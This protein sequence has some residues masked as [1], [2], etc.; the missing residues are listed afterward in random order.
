MKYPILHPSFIS[1][2][3]KL[4]HLDSLYF[5]KGGLLG[6]TQQLIG[7]SCGLTISYL[8]GHYVSKQVFG[9]YTLVLSVLGLFNFLG[10]PDIDI[11]LTRS[12][13]QGYEGSLGSTVKIKLKLAI[14]G[15]PFLL[16]FSVY[17]FMTSKMQVAQAV[18]VATLLF[19]FIN[20]F[21]SYP[22]YLTGKRKFV[23]LT[24]SSI[25]ASIFFLLIVAIGIFLI[26]TTLGLVTFYLIALIIPAY[27]TFQFCQKYLIKNHRS[28]PHLLSYGTFLTLL[29]V[30]PWI[31]G[32]L[33]SV[34]LGTHIGAETLAIYAVASRFLTAV[35]KNFIVFYKPMTAKVAAQN[36]REQRQTLNQHWLKMVLLGLILFALLWLMIPFLIT[37]F[38]TEKYASAIIYGK[39]LSLALIPLPL[40]WL[41]SDIIIYQKKAKT[42]FVKSTFP[43][44]IKIC[45]YLLI[46]PIWKIEGLVFLTIVDRFTEP[47]IP[48]ISII[49][50]G[51]KN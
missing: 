23:I 3:N 9:E 1:R 41:V 40:N 19:P 25:L 36:N 11:P 4:L 8:F 46:I 30:L 37:V 6:I 15:I 43:N 51:D 35:Q 7:V 47:I 50:S 21:T 14:L 12:I 42:Q 44:I 28:D 33:G 2:L 16:G 24:L 20:T 29:S 48:I 17:Y 10:L 34:I 18:L 38:F 32:N 22:A 26:P 27:V 13:T 5:I 45:L 31:S 49:R 39:W